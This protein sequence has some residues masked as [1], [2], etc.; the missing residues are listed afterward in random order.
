MSDIV[1]QDITDYRNSP[2]HRLVLTDED[3]TD[4]LQFFYPTKESSYNV[5]AI[6]R[7]DGYG[8]ERPVGWLFECQFVTAQNARESM[9]QYLDGWNS[10]RV[11][12]YLVLKPDA[13]Q[14]HGRLVTIR[15]RPPVGLVWFLR[16]GE[17][18]P[19]LVI[20]ITKALQS[21]HQNHDGTSYVKFMT[22]NTIVIAE[23]N[24]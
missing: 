13:S 4:R 3:T 11:D 1:F 23:P 17:H 16:K 5:T 8:A 22:D 15:L 2:M 6:T 10:R 14:A 7:R 21:L 18:G 24:P 9:M 12:A 20:H 19:D